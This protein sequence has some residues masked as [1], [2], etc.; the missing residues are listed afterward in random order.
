MYIV[1]QL[2][3]SK[4]G[5]KVQFTNKLFEARVT[6]FQNFDGVDAFGKVDFKLCTE[7]FTFHFT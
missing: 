7:V 6:T 5:I 4:P 3:Q 2:F 1:K